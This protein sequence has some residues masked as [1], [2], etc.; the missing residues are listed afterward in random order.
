MRA[1]VLVDHGS[2]EARA[3]AQL[4]EIAALLR[5]R[6]RETP[7]VTAHMELAEPTIA[8]AVEG[9]VRRGASEI[10]VMPYFLALGRHAA[11]DIPRLVEEASA[12]H[13]GLQ[14]TVTAPL[15]VHPGLVD[16]V[17]A[18]INEG[19]GPSRSG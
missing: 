19:G 16:A 14:V 17:A 12:G 8:A 11:R 3:N 15:G 1:V 10:I 5:E 9:C 6:L 4:E 2:R 18:R 13:P 7:V